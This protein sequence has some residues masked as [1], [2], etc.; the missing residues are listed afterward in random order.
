MQSNAY[1]EY[2]YS[3]LFFASGFFMDVYSTSLVRE[4]TLMEK[5]A[6]VKEQIQLFKIENPIIYKET[7]EGD[8]GRYGLTPEQ[9][10]MNDDWLYADGNPEPIDKHMELI[11]NLKFLEW[12]LWIEKTDNKGLI[13]DYHAYYKTQ[14]ENYNWPV[15]RESKQLRQ[16]VETISKVVQVSYTWLSNPDEELPNLY[17][18]LKANQLIHPDTTEEQL[19]AI[20][21][22]KPLQE[23]Q[24]INWIATKN[25]LAYFID[26]IYPNKIHFNI[27]QWRVA[28]KCFTNGKSLA[29]SKENYLGNANKKHS[30]KPKNYQIIDEILK[31]L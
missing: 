28:E 24:P 26:S 15:Y 11:I 16:L 14:K 4:Y 5:I 18:L 19:K 30:G 10:K 31:A 27:E 6:Q 17:Q 22:A 12:L 9:V 7:L 20:F 3:H 8:D 29:Q 1:I 21:T 2:I 13:D 25:L 23:I